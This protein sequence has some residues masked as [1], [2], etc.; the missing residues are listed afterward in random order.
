[1]YNVILNK[2][3]KKKYLK[4]KK[5]LNGLQKRKEITLL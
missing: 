2:N 3:K 5:K 4:K 1:M